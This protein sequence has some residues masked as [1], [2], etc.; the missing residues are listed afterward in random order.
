MFR[1]QVRTPRGYFQFTTN[2]LTIIIAFTK[3]LVNSSDRGLG[4]ILRRSVL[5]GALV[6]L[7]A[8]LKRSEFK[9]IL[10]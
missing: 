5:A 4:L 7:E 2:V 3:V 6:S 9:I 8:K 1:S 10:H